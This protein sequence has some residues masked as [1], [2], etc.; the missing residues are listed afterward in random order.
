[1]SATTTSQP[2]AGQH[3]SATP[4]G[5]V[6]LLAGVVALGAIGIA[7]AQGVHTAA[8]AVADR[9]AAKEQ[10]QFQGV[11]VSKAVDYPDQIPARLGIA[12]SKAVDYPDQI[13]ARVGTA[14]SKSVD[15]PD[16]IASRLATSPSLSMIMTESLLADRYGNASTLD[17]V[18]TEGLLADRYGESAITGTGT[19]PQTGLQKGL[20]SPDRW[21][22][23]AQNEFAQHQLSRNIL[24]ERPMHATPARRPVAR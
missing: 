12:G 3:K 13:P 11:A 17:R 22:I 14:G 24:P 10:D 15:Y 19:G 9:W 6:A 20:V 21:S 23:L 8:P 16:Q 18:A 2:I 7:Y 5:A 4:F 1:M